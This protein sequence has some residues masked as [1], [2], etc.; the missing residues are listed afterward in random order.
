MVLVVGASGNLGS[1]VVR[2][3]LATGRPVRAM[4]RQPG[5]AG[6]LEEW[7]AGVVEGDL[8]D[9]AS[10]ERACDGVS[11]VVASAHAALGR[12]RNCPQTV[13][14]TGNRTLIDVAQAEGVSHFVYVSA[15]GAVSDHPV[16]FFRIKYETGEYL[17]S[18]GLS[19]SI[20]SG[21]AFMETQNGIAGSSVADKGKAILFGRG[22][23][24]SNYV[25]VIDVAKFV[26]LAL[27]DHRL[28]RRVVEV[29]GP[30]NLTQSEVIDLYEL[31]TGRRARR[32]HI[33]VPVLRALRVLIGPF[34]SLARR[35]LTIGIVLATEEFPFDMTETLKEFPME[36]TRYED[37]IRSWHEQRIVS[38]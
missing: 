31:V 30:E 20:V 21:A 19:W 10:V 26:V 3:V 16:D 37:V 8:L 34:S 7:G 17:Q 25:S 11:S 28:R 29:G 35:L 6:Q 38:V 33:P 14:A 13:D 5:A 12:G 15:I 32:T 24:R 1:E 22:D 36:L 9:R 18:S 27:D 2:Q 4:T 23:T